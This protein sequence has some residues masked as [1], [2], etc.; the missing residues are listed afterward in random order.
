MS[1]LKAYKC[2]FL[3]L[4]IYYVEGT[5]KTV[6]SLVFIRFRIVFS[7]VQLGCGGVLSTD[8]V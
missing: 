4:S 2:F 3:C 7:G 5:N 1:C 8:I 6:F